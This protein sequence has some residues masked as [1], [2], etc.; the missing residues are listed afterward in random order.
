MNAI[1]MLRMTFGTTP[2][3]EVMWDALDRLARLV[4]ATQRR[5]ALFGGPSRLAYTEANNEY[6]TALTAVLGEGE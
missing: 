5:D 6:L 2:P 1:K 4:E 3:T